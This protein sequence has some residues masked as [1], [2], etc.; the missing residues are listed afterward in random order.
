M[1]FPLNLKF[2]ILAFV[3]QVY[4]SDKDGK[5]LFY[6]YKQYWKLKEKIIIYNNRQKGKELYQIN[7]DRIIDFSPRLDISDSNGRAIVSLKRSGWKS[8][9]KGQWE[10][11]IDGN[12]KYKIIEENPI[13][14][15]VDALVG[16]IP[17]V[18]IFCGLFLNPKF[19]IIDNDGQDVARVTKKRS[20]FESNFG[21]DNLRDLSEEEKTL[22]AFSGVVIALFERTRG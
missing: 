14:K 21:I 9:I 4:L 12:V 1:E 13:I 7:A 10:I 3:P 16:E 17:L 15:F 6:I 20:F 19:K 5:E 2:K 18:G 22:I 8:L 11:I